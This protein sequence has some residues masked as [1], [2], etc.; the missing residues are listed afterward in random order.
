[1]TEVNVPYV[2]LGPGPSYDTLGSA[3]GHPVINVTGTATS[4]SR[5][6]LRL[7][8]VGVH[9]DITLLQAIR[10]WIEGDYAVVPREL[11]YPPDKTEQQVDQ[12]NAQDFQQSQTSA[13]TVALRKL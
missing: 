7:M 11:V 13:E 3:D 2:E 6:Q 9:P 4:T 8:T 12:E 10:G 1:T 5:G